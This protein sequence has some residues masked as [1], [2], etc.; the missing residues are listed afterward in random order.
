MSQSVETR[1]LIVE[2][3]LRLQECL[4]DML[5]SYGYQHVMVATSLGEAE[6]KIASQSYDVVILDLLLPDSAGV[7]TLRRLKE[8][9]SYAAVFV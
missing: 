7:E 8:I 6:R 9:T 3:D 2:D 4:V 1:V 5:G